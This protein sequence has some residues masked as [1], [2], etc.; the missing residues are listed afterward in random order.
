MGGGTGVG[1]YWDALLASRPDLRAAFPEVQSG[2]HRRLREWADGRWRTEGTSFLL[3]S[4]STDGYEIT[5]EDRADGGVDV[6]GYLD[7][8]SGLGEAAR[9]LADALEAAGVTV[10][11]V[12]IGGTASPLLDDASIP[13]LD[14]SLRHDT[15]IVVMTAEQLPSIHQQLGAGA[16]AGRR[17]IGYWFWELS[18]PSAQARRSAPMVDEVWTPTTFVRDAFAGRIPAPVRLAPLPRPAPEPSGLT[19]ADF[20]LPEDAFVVLCSFDLLSVS[21]RK[22]PEGT[23]AAFCRAFEP[24]EGPLLVIKTINGHRR[25]SE[26]ERI[27]LAIAGRP[28][29]RLWDETLDRDDHLALVGAADCLISL[30]RSEGLGL[31]LLEAMALGTPVVTTRYSGPADFL[32]DHCAE[33]IG[34]ELVPVTNGDGAYADSAMWAE[35]DVG[36]AAAALRRLAQDPARRA[37]LAT[38]G[39]VAVERLPDRR[40]AGEALRSLLRR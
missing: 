32:D 10:A 15:A 40:T 34:Y 20:D 8:A 38:A 18:E 29:I 21:E 33:T 6:I 22:N 30:H 26:L 9:E 1:R 39:R 27:R 2:R 31:H 25:W 4:E 11:R 24:G 36:A 37:E 23:V 19:R 12:A 28:D 17:T 35:P 3:R 5:D 14:Q 13:P 7:R 16:L